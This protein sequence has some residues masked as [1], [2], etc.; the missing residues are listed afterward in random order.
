MS[1]VPAYAIPDNLPAPV[2]SGA[3]IQSFTDVWGDVWVAKNGVNGGR[4]KR[5]RDA[6]YAKWFR[7]A[8]I[9]IAGAAVLTLDTM[10]KDDYGLYSAAAFTVPVAGWYDVVFQLAVTATATGQWCSARINVNAA[11]QG[12]M[13]AHSGAAAAISATCIQQL[14][15]NAGDTV[16][17]VAE[18]SV[19]LACTPLVYW[20][21]A[22]LQYRGTG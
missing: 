17:A 15:F 4:W 22:T 1:L 18:A 20:T 2:T 14:A 19:S 6:I 21:Y 8:A 13:R 3:T 5:A 9:S 12:I 7:N 11:L 16:N 10:T